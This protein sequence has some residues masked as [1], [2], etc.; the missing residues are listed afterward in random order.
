VNRLPPA[1]PRPYPPPLVVRTNG[2]AVAALVAGILWFTWIGAVLGVILGHRARRQVRAAHGWQRGD[3]MALAG[4]VLGYS[5]L[6]VLL[7]TVVA[8]ATDQAS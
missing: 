4:L 7:F 5:G 6:A 8:L 3:G 2:L 1:P